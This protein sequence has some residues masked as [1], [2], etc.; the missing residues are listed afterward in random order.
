MD[1]FDLKK[2]LS[3]NKLTEASRKISE[4]TSLEKNLEKRITNLLKKRNPTVDIT[5]IAKET[6]KWLDAEK[7]LITATNAAGDDYIKDVIIPIE[8][9]L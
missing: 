5:L 1:N 6:K 9:N 3:E 8:G 2:Y 4:N 7:N